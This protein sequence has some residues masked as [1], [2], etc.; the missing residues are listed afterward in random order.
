MSLFTVNPEPQPRILPTGS[1]L[2]RTWQKVELRGPQTCLCVNSCVRSK[3]ITESFIVWW[4]VLATAQETLVGEQPTGPDCFLYVIQYSSI[5]TINSN[6]L[7]L[8]INP[9]LRNL[10]ISWKGRVVDHYTV[11]RYTD[12]RYTVDRYT[13]DHYTIQHV[14]LCHI[15]STDLCKWCK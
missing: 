14:F 10:N 11:D 12:D 15:F 6:S 3:Q 1:S 5:L 7:I 2:V 8:T 9:S 4:R 13:L